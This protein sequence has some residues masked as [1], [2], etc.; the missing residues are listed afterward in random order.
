MADQNENVVLNC[1]KPRLLRVTISLEIHCLVHAYL[2][3][4]GSWQLQSFCTEYVCD[5]T[6]KRGTQ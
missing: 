1:L 3:N 2:V 5:T 6:S 4:F